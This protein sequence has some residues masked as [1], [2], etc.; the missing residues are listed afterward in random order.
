[1]HNNATIMSV[2]LIVLAAHPTG[3]GIASFWPARQGIRDEHPRRRH[4]YPP[5]RDRRGPGAPV[6]NGP[7]W[8]MIP[9][10]LGVIASPVAVLALL[11]IMLSDDSVRNAGSYAAGWIV[12]VSVL[13][14]FWI[15]VLALTDTALQERD[16]AVR[17]LHGVVAVCALGGSVVIY[18]RA[19]RTLARVAAASTP[20]TLVAAVP[21]LPGILRATDRYTA[22]RS[23]AL[24]LGVFC[25]NPMN[26]ALV[27]ATAIDITESDLA[28][29]G[30]TLLGVGFVLAAAIP[31]VVPL[32]I[33]ISRGDAARPVFRRMREWVLR[34]NGFISAGLL[35]VVGVLQAERA[36][37]G[38]FR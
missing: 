30:R 19:H 35:L 28:P 26:V 10:T 18:R 6:V 31:V 17:V 15:G 23:F 33:L 29:V 5:P 34:N 13:L 9:V 36:L 25:L 12:A 2:V 27:A 32:V 4:P 38:A 7:I 22:R 24:G 20:D 1:M 14:A 37:D 8:Q 16:T 21:Q 3:R 11:G